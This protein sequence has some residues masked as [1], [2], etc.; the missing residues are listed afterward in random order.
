MPLNTDIW[1]E[2]TMEVKDGD[3]FRIL[4]R[5]ISTGAVA[6]EKFEYLPGY[7]YMP[8]GVTQRTWRQVAGNYTGV[9]EIDTSK[10][11]TPNTNIGQRVQMTDGSGSTTW[12]YDGRG[13]VISEVKVISGQSFTTS[14][15]YNSADMPVTM[16]YPDGET[17]T[18]TYDS[19]GLMETFANLSSQSPFTYMAGTTYD[20]AGRLTTLQLGGSAGN[21]VITR[22]MTYYPWTDSVNG[23]KLHW[24]TA[25]STSDT[26]SLQRLEYDYDPVGN[27]EWIKNYNAGLNRATLQTQYFT[28]DAL[29][30]LSSAEAVGGGID[31]GEYPSTGYLFDPN[32][33]NLVENGDRDIHYD[34]PTHP[35]A[36][37][38][39]EEDGLLQTEYSYDANGN[40]T[41]REFNG[42]AQQFAYDAENRLVMATGEIPA[43]TA[44]ASPAPTATPTPSLTPTT[45]LTPVPTMTRWGVETIVVPWPPTEV[46]MI[47]PM[48][49]ANL[50]IERTLED[51]TEGPTGTATPTV[52]TTPIVSNTPTLTPTNYP[53]PTPSPTANTMLFEPSTFARKSLSL[54]VNSEP[55]FGEESGNFQ[56]GAE[57]PWSYRANMTISNPGASA[58]LAGYSVRMTL[59]TAAL[60][61]AGKLRADGNDLRVIWFDGTSYIQ[62][63]RVAET[64]FNSTTTEVWFKLQSALPAGGSDGSYYIYYGNPVAGL[65]PSD[66]ANVYLVWDD[67]TGTTLNTSLWTGSG[68]VTI[69]NGSANLP[70]ESNLFG[71][72]AM[73][74]VEMVARVQV[75][76]GNEYAWWGL[77]EELST[78]PANFIVFE[79]TSDSF[80]GWTR[81]DWADNPLTIAVPTGG[82]TN[83]HTYTLR[84]LPDNAVWM[85]DGTQVGSTTENVP[86]VAMYA[87]VYAYALPLTVDWVRIR[88]LS[89]V[90]PVVQVNLDIVTTSTPTLQATPI[91]TST[92]TVTATSTPTTGVTTLPPTNTPTSTPTSTPT[93]TATRTPTATPTNTATRT[94]TSTPT[95]TATRTSTSTPT[96]TA[97]RTPTS[98]LTN[99]PTNT[100]TFT[101]SAT[102]TATQSPTPTATPTTVPPTPVPLNAVYTY[103]GDGNMVKSV[104]NNVTTYYPGRH[105][106]KEV[107]GTTERTQ[108]FYQ[109]AGQTIAVR[110]NGELKWILSDHLGS[111]SVTANADGTWN[112]ELRYTP[113]GETR[114]NSG[115]TPSDY[116]YTGQLQQAELGLYYYVA[117]WYDPALGRFLSADSIIPGA[118]NPIAWDRYAGMGNNPIRF[119]DPTGHA[120]AC[121]DGDLAGGCGSAGVFVPKPTST[122]TPGLIWKG[123]PTATPTITPTVTASPTST[124]APV[125]KPAA[126]TPGPVYGQGPTTTPTPPP[127]NLE[128]AGDVIED[129]GMVITDIVYERMLGIHIPGFIGMGID[130][131]AQVVRDWNNPISIYQKA[132]RASLAMG[133]GQ[134]AFAA[135]SAGAVLFT[136]A[137]FYTGVGAGVLGA[138]GYIVGNK[139]ASNLMDE[140]NNKWVYPA[141][142]Q[143]VP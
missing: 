20:A 21:P 45:S 127:P 29:S 92:S 102:P 10:E 113:Y 84:K 120:Q 18:M 79:K 50:P 72:L 16:T 37:T 32:T 1:Y 26:D 75:G 93:N 6:A 111:T 14:Y 2:L 98:T 65:P 62:L 106:N 131:G 126:T 129:S 27:I 33:G 97:T 77:E 4:V 125:L 53:S 64:A 142:N 57:G 117:R 114:Y 122:P 101:P 58:L 51:S 40:M 70:V 73:N 95:S 99:T 7:K 11:I 130:G 140:A 3:R 25:G 104:V 63:D 139:Y 35:H 141:I 34:D 36:A 67:F 17:V 86:S 49:G 116:R 47:A 88:L 103:D 66:R 13:R 94:P 124:T 138:T 100:P 143:F 42:A 82:L 133:E 81:S 61:A 87:S 41:S 137:S 74:S 46:V 109:A 115:L 54:L 110:T 121:A 55:R 135:G 89:A 23:G 76:G 39:L 96:N 48:V 59:D 71:S 19:Q 12:N 24:M 28:Y 128:V 22:Q 80:Y 83:P 108:K 132:A 105:Y 38:S 43:P 107:N 56:I 52:T 68:G 69:S 134:I 78:D 30:R 15:T 119:K 31:Q 85:I 112:S 123:V 136:A 91:P 118:G 44:T 90:E 8:D 5:N 9:L 60:V